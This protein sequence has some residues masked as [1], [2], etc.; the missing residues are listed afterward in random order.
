MSPLALL[1]CRMVEVAPILSEYIK[2]T[3]YISLNYTFKKLMSSELL[4]VR[5]YKCTLRPPINI[6]LRITLKLYNVYN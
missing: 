4:Q 6:T 5:N 3:V 1:Y 2:I